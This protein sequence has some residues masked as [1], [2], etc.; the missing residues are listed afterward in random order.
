M[1]VHTPYYFFPS[2]TVV[3]LMSSKGTGM[4]EDGVGVRIGVGEGVRGGGCAAPVSPGGRLF[5]LFCAAVLACL[6]CRGMH[7]HIRPTG[8]ALEADRVV[9]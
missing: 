2:H 5:S 4:M 1:K 3:T 9:R 8:Q 7:T 6:S